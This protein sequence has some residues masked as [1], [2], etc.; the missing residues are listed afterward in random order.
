MR[1][2]KRN[3]RISLH[4]HVP[5]SLTSKIQ[6]K[7]ACHERSKACELTRRMAVKFSD[8]H[9]RHFSPNE[10]RIFQAHTGR[11]LT[12][13]QIS[14]L[15]Q[16]GVVPEHRARLAGGAIAFPTEARRCARDSAGPSRPPSRVAGLSRR[17]RGSAVRRQAN[18]SMRRITGR[19]APAHKRMAAIFG[20]E[21][22][23]EALWLR[24]VRSRGG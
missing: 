11:N 4:V 5:L 20:Q 2:Q 8:T 13:G 3:I 6:A 23:G 18:L 14:N 16:R 21:L 22:D 9:D 1:Q 10:A 12:G 24:S 19:M 17:F 7:S 15:E